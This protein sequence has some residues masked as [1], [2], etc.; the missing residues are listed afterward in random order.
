M[1]AKIQ[2]WACGE[3]YLT[4][5]H[6]GKSVTY[7]GIT[8]SIC[9]TSHACDE[10]G[11][12]LFCES[13]V[14]ENRRAWN[15]FRKSATMAPLGCEI[16]SMRV[17]AGLTQRR[18]ADLFGGGPVAFSKYENDDLIPDEAMNKLLR[19]AIAYP[20]IIQRLEG[21]LI[22]RVAV[23]HVSFNAEDDEHARW[24]SSTIA[25]RKRVSGSITG[26]IS[27]RSFDVRPSQEPSWILQ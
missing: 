24:T 17:R 5:R 25:A 15:R 8:G 11:A 19:L 7:E 18:A 16:E 6:S 22:T 26:V 27:T 23:R 14:R 3:G 2:C 13:D 1:T 9:H 12:V 20:D 21:L 4:R 10:C